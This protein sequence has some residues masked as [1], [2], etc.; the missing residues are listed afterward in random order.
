MFSSLK[1]FI[2]NMAKYENNSLKILGMV[3]MVLGVM[4]I[5]PVLFAIYCGDDP[6]V[7]AYPIP[8]LL[9]FGTIQYLKFK[10]NSAMSAYIGMFTLFLSW[11]LAFIV[12]S[13]PFLLYGFSP[14]DSLFEGV[15]GFTTTGASTL[16]DFE[17]LPRSLLL[18]RSFVQW[19]GGISIVMIFVFLIPMMGLGGRAF[20][21]NELAGYD[22]YN[23][24]MYMK[25]S[26]KHFISIYVLL[27]I[28]EVVLLLVAGVS[29]FDSVS[30]T[31][32]TISTGGLMATGDSVMSYSRIVQGI[33]M[34]FMFLGGTNFYLHYRAI[35]KK[36][37]TAYI[38]SQEFIWTII[39][40]AIALV[41]I[42][43][44]VLTHMSDAIISDMGVATSTLWDT[45]FTVIS[46]GTSTGYYTTDLAIWPQAA[47]MILWIMAVFGS[48]SGS[49]S[50]GVKVYRL[51][52]LKSY[53]SNGIHKMFHPND[54]RDVKIDGHSVDNQSVVSAVVVVA[55]FLLTWVIS[56][57]LLLAVEP[58][59]GMDDAIGLSIS[60]LGNL[61]INTGGY[62]FY[63]LS[64]ISKIILSF[65][66]WIGRMEVV[67]A[68]LIFTKTFWA[69]VASGMRKNNTPKTVSRQWR[70]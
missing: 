20:R 23:F 62:E 45:L 12:S 4:L 6:M 68:L 30:M 39:W 59:M 29:T 49:T 52:I 51:L 34:V 65:V 66:M 61:G 58:D 17:S 69:G 10:S 48:M 13:I 36:N 21:N 11:G 46:V 5:F 55:L 56:I 1:F 7:F 26:A 16:V 43:V 41:A 47:I 44:I 64:D 57:L 8:F 25:T 38:K 15:S 50:G 24:S 63:E 9:I 28:A 27:T 14:V 22:T 70:R 35:Y 32:S 19:A 54:V 53:I 18:W 40:F 33:I 2:R 67:M 42:S 37:P 31:L 3:E 60:A